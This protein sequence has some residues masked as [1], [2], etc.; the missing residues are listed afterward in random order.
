MKAIKKLVAR[1]ALKKVV[2]KL[3]KFL[4]SINLVSMK[5]SETT[6]AGIASLALIAIAAMIDGD[7][8]SIPDW[9]FL[10]A[11]I[12]LVIGLFRARDNNKSSEEVGAKKK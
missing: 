12:P 4:N 10:G 6:I 1:I 5:S 9:G 7:P 8:L 2:K 3:I 11:I